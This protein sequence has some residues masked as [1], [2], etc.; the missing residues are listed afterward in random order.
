[1]S[2]PA[3]SPRVQLEGRGLKPKKSFGQNFL[4][5]ETHLARIAD[6]VA[7]VCPENRRAMELGPGTGVLT[8]ALLDRGLTVTAVERDRDLVPLLADRFHDDIEAGKLTL[9]EDN[10]VTVE[11]AKG[12]P[13]G[14]VLCGNLPYHLSGSLLARPVDERERI[15]AAVFLLQLEV[16]QRIAS[17]PGSKAY[18][19]LSVLC[20]YGYDLELTHTVPRGAFWPVPDVDGGV[21]TMVRL[22]APRG[23][24]VP[25]AALRKVV[26]TCFEQRRKTI[27]NGL[28]KLG[29]PD[30]LLEAAGVA[31]GV[32]AE[33]VEVEGFVALAQAYAARGEADA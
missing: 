4:T 9:L 28:K 33:T 21:L 22:P 6:E 5:D 7:R 19:V 17:G 27:R 18:G 12:L 25:V 24:D 8:A 2:R 10:A 26:K 30:A 29:D 32:R 16:A 13:E 1:L 20:G 14:G 11:L 31:A 15:D 23:G 3:L